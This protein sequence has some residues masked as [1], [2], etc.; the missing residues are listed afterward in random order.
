MRWMI[1]DSTSDN[2]EIQA[3]AMPLLVI[4]RQFLNY[5]LSGNIGEITP[6]ND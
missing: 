5:I 6:T 1:A 2:T 4:R 3:R